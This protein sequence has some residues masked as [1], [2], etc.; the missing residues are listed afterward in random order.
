MQKNRKRAASESLV[1]LLVLAAIVV[2]VNLLGIFAHGRVDTTEKELFSL[3]QGSRDLVSRLSDR[4]EI[5]AYFS[6]E[7]PPPHNATERYLRDL[8]A[9]YKD[10]S[11]GKVS[12]RF[13]HPKDE[14]SQEAARRDGVMPVQDQVLKADSFSVQEGYR[15]L[16]FHYLGDSRTMPQVSTTAGLEYEIT[17]TIKQLVGDEVA[18]GVLSGH[19][20]PTLAQGLSS[21]KGY[22]PTYGLKEVS[23]AEPLPESLK[24]L[25]IIEPGT[26][27]SDAELRNID[28][29]VM[30]GGSL[31]VFGGTRKTDLSQGQPT[32]L[33]IDTGLSKLLEAWGVS[34]GDAIVADA[35]CGS[36][37]LPTQLG[38]PVAVPYPPA[39]IVTFDETQREHPVAF[40]LD[41]VPMP[42]V[43]PITVQ[44]EAPEG[45]TRTVIARSTKDSWLMR[46][47]RIDLSARE[48]WQI[49][50]YEGPFDL[51]VAV[52]GRLP[53]AFAAQSSPSPADDA[54]ANAP[55]Q[56]EKDVHVLVFGSGAML[57]DEF[58]PPPGQRGQFLGGAVAFALNAVDYLANDSDLI[59]IRAKNVEDPAL[60]VPA[61]VKEAEATAREAYEEQDEEKF[62]A[63]LDRRK[64]AVDAWDRKKSLYRWGNM[65]G[66]PLAFALFGVLR[67]RMRKSKKQSLSL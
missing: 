22:L 19:E 18:I 27:L 48:R 64:D 36:A 51:G 11:G 12:V 9:E 33:T 34:L 56:A 5:R 7:L 49:P 41:Q 21:L 10:A 52:S 53:S 42:Y 58:M 35:Q 23:A 37:R 57:R 2:A 31:G 62:Q 43:T 40:R 13:I 60:E 28:R 30:R 50:G 16:S 38:F 25:L 47:E 26:P 66:L 20:G 8:L 39:P 4:L 55:A 67:W 1:F 44:S 15:G 54:A 29:F 3:S 61:S 63:A 65:A 14:E 24:A 32:S 6:E 17:Q 45:V 59:A 46:G